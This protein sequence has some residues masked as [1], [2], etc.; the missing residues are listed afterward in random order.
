MLS[1]RIQISDVTC[2]AWREVGI[3]WVAAL[4]RRVNWVVGIVAVGWVIRIVGIVWIWWIIWI[5]WEVG[6]WWVVRIIGIVGIWWVIWIVGVVWIGWII[7]V[8]GKS[9]PVI[10]LILVP[11]LVLLGIPPLPD[12][13]GVP[14]DLFKCHM[15]SLK[16]T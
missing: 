2:L 11:C 3:V 13:T 7:R 6:I 15:Q 4:I 5:I 16:V 12:D 1:S 9:Y 8:V 14:H 10:P